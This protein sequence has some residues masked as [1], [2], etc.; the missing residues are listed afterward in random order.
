[1]VFLKYLQF[2]FIYQ[3]LHRFNTLGEKV[4]LTKHELEFFIFFAKR[5]AELE[6]TVDRIVKFRKSDESAELEKFFMISVK[7]NEDEEKFNSFDTRYFSILKRVA[8]LKF[9]NERIWID[10]KDFSPLS[11][12]VHLFEKLLQQKIILPKGDYTL[13]NASFEINYIRIL[14]I[15][16]VTF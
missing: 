10:D 4:E 11:K 2:F 7:S 15:T 8:L 5:H 13:Q 9:S 3:L 1:M 12:K 14:F 16:T 6:E